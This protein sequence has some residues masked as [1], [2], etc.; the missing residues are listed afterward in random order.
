MSDQTPA[1]TLYVRVPVDLHTKFKLAAFSRGVT[2]QKAAAKAME[3][4]VASSADAIAAIGLRIT[5]E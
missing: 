5:A 3:D 2:M 4:Y 1:A